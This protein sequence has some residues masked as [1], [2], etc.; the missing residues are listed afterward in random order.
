M[1]LCFTSPPLLLW[2]PHP[3]FRFD[4]ETVRDA[5]DVVKV[6]DH[7]RRDSDAFVVESLRSE[8]RDVV[9]RHLPRGQ[10]EPRRIVAEGFVG[11]AELRFAVVEEQRLCD[12]VIPGLPTEVFSV[13]ERSVVALIDVTHHR[14]YHFSLRRGQGVGRLHQCQVQAHRRLQA[15]PVPAHHFEDVRDATGS[16]GGESVDFRHSA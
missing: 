5:V 13:R 12:L 10:R 8:S 7:L 15:A 11:I 9:C 3:R 6:G 14:S 16:L 4:A 2:R 1:P